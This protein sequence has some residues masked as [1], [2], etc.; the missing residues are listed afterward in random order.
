MFAWADLN[1]IP[2]LAIGTNERLELLSN[3][4]MITD[5]TPIVHTSNLTNP[6]TTV[7]GQSIV[8]VADVGYSPAVGSWVNFV[9]A[10]YVGGILIQGIYQVLT[11]ASPNFTIDTGILATSGVSGG[12]TVAAYTSHSGTPNIT[13]TVGAYAFFDTQT[14]LVGVSTTVGGLTILGDYNVA[15]TAGPINTIT[16]PGNA[17]SNATVNENSGNVRTEYLLQLPIETFSSGAFG[18]GLFGAGLFGMGAASTTG[19]SLVQWSLDKWGENLVAAFAGGTV[20]QWVPPVAQGNVA[21]PVSGAPQAVNGLMTASPEQ[22]VMAWGI[23]SASLGQQDPLLIGWCDVADLNDWTAS[24]TNQAGTFRLSNGSRIVSGEWFGLSGLLWTDV[25]VWIVSYIGFPFIYSF[26]QIGKNSGLI[27]QNAVGV[28]GTKVAWMEPHDF[29]VYEGGSVQPVICTVRDFVFNNIDQAYSDAVF[30]AVN[31]VADEITWWFPTMGSNGVCNAYVKWNIVENF[32]DYGPAELPGT[33]PVLEISAWSDHSVFGNPIGAFYTGL[34]EQFETSNDFDGAV[35][36]ASLLSG[37]YNL[38]QGQE[39]IFLERILPDFV[40]NSGG[41]INVTVYVADYTSAPADE[42]RTYGPYLVTAT[43]PFLIVG[44]RG[45]V[46][47]IQVDCPYP[48]TFFRYG[49][50]LAVI[51]PDGRS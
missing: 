7:M 17:G 3:G 42:I 27:S 28:I 49:N 34:L 31:T 14:F 35:Y 40:F 5:I 39:F 25:D 33:P 46:L 10:A 32:W 16:G 30:C 41:Q 20:Y 51:Q 2:Y 26:N 21:A 9:N 12:G 6:F 38:A 4:G 1:G 36:P 19:I 48:N 13:F 50:P 45:R 29:F 24:A 8:T 11:S 23:Y 43:T 15:A 37:W 47:R 22:Q 18:A 44:A